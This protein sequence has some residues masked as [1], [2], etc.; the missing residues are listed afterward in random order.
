MQ[1]HRGG[2]EEAGAVPEQPEDIAKEEAGAPQ[3]Q[4]CP[5]RTFSQNHTVDNNALHFI[6][7]DSF[8]DAS[9]FWSS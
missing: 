1:P 4:E 9:A 5:G 3:M 6:V 2:A 8:H 7:L